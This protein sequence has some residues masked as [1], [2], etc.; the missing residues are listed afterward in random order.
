MADIT[1]ELTQ[2]QERNITISRDECIRK[3]EDTI[4]QYRNAFPDPANINTPDD[5]LSL[6][7]TCIQMA[8]YD[9]LTGQT[10]FKQ[11]LLGYISSA[12]RVMPGFAHEY[13]R[14]ALGFGYAAARAYETYREDAYLDYAKEAWSLGKKFTILEEDIS[15]GFIP[16]KNFTLQKSCNAG[17]APLPL[18]TR[19]THGFEASLVGGTFMTNRTDNSEIDAWST[20]LT[21]NEIYLSAASTTIGFLF[22]QMQLKDSGLFA[23]SVFVN[24]RDK[25]NMDRKPSGYENALIMQGMSIF[26]SVGPSTSEYNATIK[27]LVVAVTSNPDWHNNAGILSVSDGNDTP[28]YLPR[29][30]MQVY[31]A[32]TD[33]DFREYI[34]AYLSIQYNATMEN[35]LGNNPSAGR[36]QSRKIA[37]LLAATAILPSETIVPGPSSP[38]IPIPMRTTN[39]TSTTTVSVA[40]IVGGVLGGLAFVAILVVCLLYWR[41]R[42]KHTTPVTSNSKS[43]NILAASTQDYFQDQILPRQRIY[44]RDP[45]VKQLEKWDDAPPDYA[46]LPG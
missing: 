12:E 13:S 42:T 1:L 22:N 23:G 21:T 6:A 10:K 3:T 16:I 7:Q 28:S 30:L 39:E 14:V 29:G 11:T 40:Q 17:K 45:D 41:R 25:C 44:R 19:I 8:D 27:D 26:S 4:V 35:T 46:T 32:T 20:G 24:E 33:M 38:S 43:S 9:A 31:N 18:D 34:S 2:V 5:F 37:V 36:L 15:A